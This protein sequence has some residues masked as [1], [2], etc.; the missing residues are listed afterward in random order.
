MPQEKGVL[1]PQEGEG[2]M[3]AVHPPVTPQL[4]FVL[5]GG[6]VRLGVLLLLLRLWAGFAATGC[7]L[8]L[9]RLPAELRAGVSAWLGS[10]LPLPHSPP[11]TAG[12]AGQASLVPS[13]G[14]LGQLQW[15]NGPGGAVG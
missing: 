1:E 4:G 3:A 8:F 13:G 6:A 14:T 7:L 5:G 2:M 9:H 15:R 10:A 11:K 12:T